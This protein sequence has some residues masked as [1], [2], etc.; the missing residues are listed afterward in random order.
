MNF[1]QW[2]ATQIKN[3]PEQEQELAKKW[4]QI[5]WDGYTMSQIQEEMQDKE[6]LAEMNDERQKLGHPEKF[7]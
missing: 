6:S 5:G 4:C 3:I 7:W 1:E 2:W